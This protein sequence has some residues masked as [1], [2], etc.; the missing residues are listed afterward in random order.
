MKR[1]RREEKEKIKREMKEEKEKMKR[2]MKQKRKEEKKIA[3]K[4]PLQDETQAAASKR[5]RF[6]L[7][8]PRFNLQWDFQLPDIPDLEDAMNRPLGIVTQ[9]KRKFDLQDET[10]VPAS[11]HARYDDSE[12]RRTQS[13]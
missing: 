10:Q 12:P 9:E 5:V 3:S 8:E 13:W 11:K 7:R 1:E 6:D 2:E 4:R